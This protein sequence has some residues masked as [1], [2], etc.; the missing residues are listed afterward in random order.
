Y[1]SDD[2]SEVSISFEWRHGE[3]S[4][5][6][7]G[8]MDG[9][10]R[11]DGEMMIEE[12]KSTRYPVFDDVFSYKNEHLAQ[13]KFYGYMYLKS[14][15]L[16]EI[17]GR[18]AYIQTSDYQ[19]RYFE[20]VFNLDELEKFFDH[21]MIVYAEWLKIL[22]EHINLK[23]ASLGDIDFPFTSYRRGQRE[24]MRAVY[25]TMLD[26]DILYVIAPTGIGKTMASLFSSLKA[27]RDENQKIFYLTAKT[28][29][30]KI[31]LESMAILH[32]KGL[33]TKTLE[34]T[35]KDAIC[36]L[37][38]RECNPEKCPFTVGFF[39]RLKDATVDIFTHEK[40]MTRPVIEAYARKHQICPFE[41]SL[42][43]SFYVDVLVCDY[44]YVFDP[45]TH[46]IRYFD[47]T[48]YKPL[49]LVDEA[50]NLISRSRDMYSST[51]RISDFINLRRLSSKIKPSLRHTL[52]KVLDLFS[53]F[54]AK[55]GDENF[56][57]Y[58]KVDQD[59]LDALQ[60]LMRKIENTLKENPNYAKKTD[61]L[62]SYFLILSFIKIHEFYN[63]L[64][65]TNITRHDGDIEVSL[66]CLD[67]SP[68]LL[69]T[70]KN[71]AFGS[72]MMSATLYPIE[73]YQELLTQGAG[74]TLKI[75]SPFNPDHLKLVIMH[76]ISTRYQ[77]RTNSI[78]AVIDAIVTVINSKKGNYIVFFPSYQ[79][80]NQV[81]NQL[82]IH[83]EAD[84]IIQEKEM[85]TA[86][87]EITVQR[88]K[89]DSKRSQ[90]AL[91]VMGG[92]FSEG[93]DYIGDMLNGVI[94]VGVG[95]PMLNEENN[96]LK[97]YYQEKFKKGFDYAYKYPGMNKVIQAIGRIIRT[98]TD[99]GIGLLIDDR[100]DSVSYRKLY[101][102][103]WHDKE[104]VQDI[105]QLSVVL[106]N[107]WTKMQKK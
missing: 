78:Q 22:D 63:E 11:R 6:L 33:E 57:T 102:P 15:L 2:A 30:K 85:S 41:F 90:L 104:K 7:S 61:V 76:R 49:L 21:S 34:I 29:G 95:L 38:K 73:Y 35:S 105:K 10:L 79:Y 82:P 4:I 81:L 32:E 80:L 28:I 64:Y 70:I 75:Q 94:V 12:I 3:K 18:I 39:D 5:L 1:L 101:P 56:I 40:L 67:A 46:L 48:N 97:A 68:F 91:F 62:E 107:F 103:E 14:K 66:R 53:L 42:N 17:R 27:L 98:D 100:F 96:Q 58:E 26:D 25:Q 72:I 9:L 47:E 93:I 13:L 77:D 23:M 8:R 92:L 55:L 37:D 59:F 16:D 71:K 89:A 52:K 74:E 31:A 99:Y 36:F 106:S 88:F 83:I 44:N 54:D 60:T 24:M 45:R 69:D 87:R 20:F 51:L 86:L 84:L 50:H 19:V 65:V 43:V